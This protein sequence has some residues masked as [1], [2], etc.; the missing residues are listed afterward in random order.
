MSKLE[1]PPL[2]T[3]PNPLGFWDLAM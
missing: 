3:H 1:I 2:L